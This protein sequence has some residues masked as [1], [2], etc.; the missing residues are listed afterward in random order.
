MSIPV[1]VVNFDELAQALAINGT[2]INIDTTP[3]EDI[4]NKYF[5]EIIDI[6][7]KL[8]ALKDIKGIQKVKGF[9][10]VGEA[11]SFTPSKDILITGFSFSQS[12]FDGGT[13]DYWDLSVNAGGTE[14]ISI[15]ENIYS[16]D[17]LQHKYFEKYYPVPAGYEI[18]IK[19]NNTGITK[20]YWCD[21]EYLELI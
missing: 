5:P 21:L 20:A 14:S 8:L 3:I 2:E 15:L 11:F 7:K 16:K 6:L 12:V 18:K 10:G 17:T 13:M 9:A 1:Y 4:L 19:P